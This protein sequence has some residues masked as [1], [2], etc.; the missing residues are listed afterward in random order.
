MRKIEQECAHHG[1]PASVLMENAGK[2][3]AGAVIEITDKTRKNIIVLVGPGNNGGDGLVAGR[4]LYD[5]GDKVC[6]YLLRSRP[7][8]DPNLALVRER[9]IDIIE[10]SRDKDLS[11]LEK[12]LMSSDVVIDAV[13]GTGKS[14]KIDGDFARVLGKVGEIKTRCRDMT[15]FALDLPSG[16]DADI[17]TIDPACLNADYTIT[18]GFPKPGLFN[19]PGAEKAG[20][21]RIVDIGIPAGFAA[22]VSPEL[23][24]DGWVRSVLPQRP[25]VA[26]KGTFG[27]VM[28][29]A[30]SLNYIGAAFL[31]CTG[32]MR[33]GAG[34]VTLAIPESLQP[35]LASKLTEVTYLPL[36]ESGK[37]VLSS[38]SVKLIR[39]AIRDYNVL[40]VGCGLSR[41]RE[42]GGLVESLVFDNDRT[43]IPMVIDADG[44]NI[45][46]EVI[47]RDGGWHRLPDDAILTPHPGEMA[48]LTDMAVD[49]IQADRTGVAVNAAREWHKTIVLK[50]AYTVIAAPDGR[51]MIS[52]FANPSL[53]SAGTGD[54]LAGAIAGL[55]AQGISLF[56]AAVIGVYLHGKAGEM[57]CKLLGDTGM[58]AGDLLPVLPVAIKQIKEIQTDREGGK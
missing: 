51:I 45:L 26:N 12:C 58:V 8:D 21:V 33:V 1:L 53:A 56:E 43:E 44:L 18:L 9:E 29:V 14:R 4:Y 24:T 41:G 20:R 48:R 17:G 23:V 19:M 32:A 42:V 35:I 36:P 15:V 57:V 10:S 38:D 46:S 37:G 40:L 3:V 27:K 11:Q 25:L 5:H 31:A 50:G 7:T 49:A 13:F 6:L 55:V 22:D 54:V 30:G 52:P 47:R 34:L 28:V 39:Q 16:L 2:A